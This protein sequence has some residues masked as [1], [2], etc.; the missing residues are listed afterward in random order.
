MPG[1]MRYPG[2]EAYEAI[3]SDLAK[4]FKQV[5]TPLVLRLMDRAFGEASYSIGSLFRDL[6]RQVLK[7]FL[8]GRYRGYHCALQ[9]GV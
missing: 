7:K 3:S 6:Q 5:D 8:A 1:V 2:E 4:A 9:A